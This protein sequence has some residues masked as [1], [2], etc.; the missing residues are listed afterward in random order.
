MVT[1]TFYTNAESAT[2][3]KGANVT[4]GYH[5]A[6]TQEMVYGTTRNLTAN[7]YEQEGYT[8]NSWNTESNGSGVSYQ[9]EALVKNLSAVEGGIA[10]LYAMYQ[11]NN[12]T[13]TYA[14]DTIISD[15]QIQSRKSGSD[16]ITSSNGVYTIKKA[17]V[18]TGLYIPESVFEVGKT[19]VLSYKIQKTAGTLL[20]IGGHAAIT[21][22]ESFTID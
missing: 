4:N 20:N 8:F 13:A 22:Q 1:R 14:T 19:Y 5:E 10:N 2:F 9:D 3:T 16:T 21:N 15:N 12:Y 11:A 17:S 6:K 18:Y 7:T